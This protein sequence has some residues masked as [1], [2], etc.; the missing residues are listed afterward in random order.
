VIIKNEYEIVGDTIIIKI[1]NRKKE[2]YYSKVSLCDLD[3]L[4]SFNVKWHLFYSKT[5]K[6][7]YVSCSEYLGYVDGK[8]KYKTYYLHRFLTDAPK[9]IYVDHINYDTLDNQRENLRFTTMSQNNK[10]R[11]G[12]NQNNSSGER[13]VSW[14]KKSNKYFVQFQIEGKNVVYG[15]FEKDKLNEAIEFARE[16]RNKLYKEYA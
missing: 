7:N 11:K 2:I 13:N 10:H 16:L 14:I 8:P 12:L 6:L 3:K 5:T 4:L 15:K 1:V 9:N